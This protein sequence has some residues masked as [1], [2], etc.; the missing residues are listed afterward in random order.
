MSRWE[1]FESH[2]NLL[3][4]LQ[5]AAG[6]LA[7]DQRTY[8]P[9]QGAGMR[10]A[11]SATLS[12]LYHKTL[13]DKNYGE[14]LHKL[15]DDNTINSSQERAVAVALR[16]YNKATK[17]PTEFVERFSGAKSAA[18]QAW[19]QAKTED[20]FAAFAPHLRTLVDLSKTQAELLGGSDSLYDTLLD[21][22]DQGMTV[23][24]LKPMFQEL[25]DGL[26]ELVLGASQKEQPPLVT[27]E[28]T[29]E[30]LNRLNHRVIQD[31][32]FDMTKG[33]LDE[34]EHPFTLGIGPDDVRL[35]THNHTK[36]LLGTLSGTIHECG[37]GMYEQGLPNH[38][39][40]LGLCHAAGCGIHE[41]Q[42][43]FWENIIG[44]SMSFFQYLAP[45][46][47]EETGKMIDPQK[48]YNAANRV[49]PSLIR[50]Y[51]DE[52]TYNLHIIIRFQLELALFSGELEPEDAEGAW[53]DAYEQYL[54]IRPPN[55]QQGVLQDVHWSSAYFGYF[56][57]YTLGNLFAASF[58]TV[59]NTDLPEMWKQ[60]EKGQF[61]EILGWL[62]SR[63]HEQG[64][65]T[66]QDK[67]VHAAVGEQNHVGNLLTHLKSRQEQIFFT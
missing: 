66:T 17:L 1:H 60:V 37:H 24:F 34:S 12:G 36:D 61:S 27:T 64:F 51:A 46:I 28:F 59:M 63:V 6:V 31:L 67:I 44:S 7:W 3:H 15:N 20:N 49:V 13:I 54:G 4:N 2:L 23:S 45:I 9:P 21:E 50:I 14:V 56:P 48:L 65:L 53:A 26:S 25:G 33:R 5:G 30:E 35:T 42:S 18:H 10:A 32:G 19:V 39:R 55:A 11:Q 58:K 22:Y 57:S 38:L 16:N 29:T 47:A 41:S 40:K 43:R 52:T 62:R 8:M